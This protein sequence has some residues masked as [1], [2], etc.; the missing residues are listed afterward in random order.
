MQTTPAS[1]LA[2]EDEV[3]ND[4]FVRQKQFL[5][6]VQELGEDHRVLTQEEKSRNE[7]PRRNKIENANWGTVSTKWQHQQTKEVKKNG[8]GL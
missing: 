3:T 6:K 8:S 5:Q 4:Y 1:L 2:S 7:R